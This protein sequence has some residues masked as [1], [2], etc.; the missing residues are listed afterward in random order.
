LK[1]LKIIAALLVVFASGYSLINNDFS[2]API[3]SLLLGCL[4]IIVGVEEVQRKSN[5]G[6]LL[7]VV[8]ALVIVVSV[9]S[10]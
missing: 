2:Y 8:S 6:Y 9:F 5:C 10:F 7:F 3:S 4:L 1:Y